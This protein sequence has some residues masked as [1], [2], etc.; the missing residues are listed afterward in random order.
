[1]ASRAGSW[2]SDLASMALSGL[3]GAM[4]EG[5]RGRSFSKGHSFCKSHPQSLGPLILALLGENVDMKWTSQG[6]LAIEMGMSV[7][8]SGYRPHARR[9]TQHASKVLS[10]ACNSSLDTAPT[11]EQ[12]DNAYNIST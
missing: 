10:R 9:V 11:H 8:L 5:N 2:C 4:M 1:M 12:L 7:S 3:R 6:D